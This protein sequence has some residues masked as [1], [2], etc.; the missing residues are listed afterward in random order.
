MEQNDEGQRQVGTSG[1]WKTPPGRPPPPNGVTCEKDL[2]V[3]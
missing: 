1:E 2:G 3:V